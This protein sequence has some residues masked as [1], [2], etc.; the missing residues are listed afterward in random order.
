MIVG[1]S[2]VGTAVYTLIPIA[3]GELLGKQNVPSMMSINFLYEGLGCVI[4]TFCAG[5]MKL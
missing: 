1:L 2:S 3:S 5:K 4:A